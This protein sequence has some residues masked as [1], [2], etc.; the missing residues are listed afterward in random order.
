MI[1]EIFMKKII[2]V[3]CAAVLFV[4]S[5]SIAAYAVTAEDCAE[6]IEKEA[7]YLF[8]GEVGDVT[9]DGQ[10]SA[11][12]ARAALLAS[13]GLL[14]ENNANY[15]LE[16]ADADGDG[17]I[18]AIDARMILRVSAKLDSA[19]TITDGHQLNLFNALANSIKATGTSVRYSTLMENKDLYCDNESVLKTLNDQMNA[20]VGEEE[21][22]D[23]IADIT[24][25]KGKKVGSRGN[26][27]EATDANFPLTGKDFVSDLSMSDIA[28][29]EYKSNQSYSYQH[30]R[31]VE[32]VPSTLTSQSAE[33]TGLDSLTVYFNSEKLAKLPDNVLSTKHGKIF[34]IPDSDSLM[35][36]TGFDELN[37]AFAGLEA[38]IGTMKISFGNINFHDAYV[39]IYF[40]RE[41]MKVCA[42]EYNMYYD[43]AIKLDVDLHSLVPY[44]WV[45]GTTNIVDKEYSR[46]SYYFPDNYETIN[47]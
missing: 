21:K 8:Y 22:M 3:L 27:S 47:S 29:I 23:M 11:G 45:K 9:G 4:T 41:T 37:N 2:S 16:K 1:G 5:F 19:D 12:D 7:E 44:L 13:A 34:D 14:G 25:E 43:S 38:L 32:N 18:T 15:R 26:Y 20:L 42:A 30:T 6:K 39:T 28:S 33:L 24:K 17:K 40:D 36:G 10:F 46:L 31:Y 35:S